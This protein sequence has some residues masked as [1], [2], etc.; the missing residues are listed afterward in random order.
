LTFEEKV[1][2]APVVK[3]EIQAKTINQRSAKGSTS[4]GECSVDGK[5]I[6]VENIGRKVS[7]PISCSKK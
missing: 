2:V 1:R 4:I 5:Y 7:V 3:G 6:T